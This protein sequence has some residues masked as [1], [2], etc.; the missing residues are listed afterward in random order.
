MAG[1]SLEIRTPWGVQRVRRL[2][3]TRLESFIGEEALLRQVYR[4]VD[5]DMQ[6]LFG[7]DLWKGSRGMY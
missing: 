7:S 3:G 1:R 5:D 2:V 4:L 6:E